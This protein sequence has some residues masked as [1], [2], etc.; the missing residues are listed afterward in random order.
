MTPG[1]F[2]SPSASHAH[3]LETLNLLYE[4]DDFMLSVRQMADMGC[5]HG[6]DLEWWATRTTRDD[7]PQPLNIRCVGIDRAE[8]LSVQSRYKNI[9]Y[10]SRSFEDEILLYKQPYDVVWCHDAFQYAI[11]PF[12]TLKK[13]RMA[14]SDSSMLVLI[15]PQTTNLEYNQQA[16]DQR[17]FCYHHWTMTSLLHVL[18]V[19]GFDCANGYFKKEANDP[20]LHAVVY[21]S[22]K[23]PR[24]PAATTW[25]DLCNAGLLPGS[26]CAGINKHGYLRQRDLTLPWLDRSLHSMANH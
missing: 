15:V 13:W 6:L 24:D 16:F 10:Y 11:N 12:E 17:N 25:Y 23:D 2:S 8:S 7:K 22:Q 1:V 4:Y 18:A 20:W 26:A 9:S 21:K 19:S 5:G 14:M 3:S